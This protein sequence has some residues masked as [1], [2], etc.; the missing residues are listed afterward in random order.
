MEPGFRCSK[1]KRG[2]Y[3]YRGHIIYSDKN[4]VWWCCPDPSDMRVCHKTLRES[5]QYIDNWEEAFKD[6]RVHGN[7]IGASLQVL[8]E[9]SNRIEAM[10]KHISDSFPSIK[11]INGIIDTM[12]L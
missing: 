12:N 3:R 5:K 11:Q 4:R 8:N 9:L 10:N 1:I 2:K 7:I 6:G